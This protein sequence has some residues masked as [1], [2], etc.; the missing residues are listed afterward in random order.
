M[1]TVFFDFSGGVN[2]DTPAAVVTDA[3]T[4][5]AVIAEKKETVVLSIRGFL[6]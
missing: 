2:T 4:Q 1:V 6:I 3:L 5:K